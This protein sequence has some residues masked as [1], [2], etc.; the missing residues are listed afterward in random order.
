MLLYSI[1]PLVIMASGAFADDDIL[2]EEGVMV[3]GDDN[4]QTALDANP[5]ILVEFYAPWLVIG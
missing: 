1:V 3:L 4:F 2:L 5:F